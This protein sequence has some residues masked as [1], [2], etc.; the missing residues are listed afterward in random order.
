MKIDLPPE[1]VRWVKDALAAGR[2]STAEEA[3]LYAVNFAKAAD[4]RAELE[5]AEV[6]GG[7]FGSEEVKRFA[8]ESLGLLGL[9]PHH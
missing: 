5:A 9:P 1:T 4:L 7:A 3:I 6:E 8:L 2:F